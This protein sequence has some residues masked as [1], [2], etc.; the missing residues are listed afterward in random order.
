MI[1]QSDTVCHFT[2]RRRG[3]TNMSLILCLASRNV[4]PL[5]IPSVDGLWWRRSWFKQIELYG[6]EKVNVPTKWLLMPDVTQRLRL[7]LKSQTSICILNCGTIQFSTFIVGCT[8]FEL[9][10]CSNRSTSCT[11]V[12]LMRTLLEWL[13][14]KQNAD[15][16]T[17]TYMPP[18]TTATPAK[19]RLVHVHGSVV[20]SPTLPCM[21]KNLLNKR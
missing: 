20:A 5:L 6:F 2:S 10:S 18:D 3:A 8:I 13:W 4:A 7:C 14:W 15:C 1:T 21:K 19:H 11:A 16:C 17:S 9:S 12:S